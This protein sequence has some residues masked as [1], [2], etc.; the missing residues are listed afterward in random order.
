MDRQPAA[1][2]VRNSH[3]HSRSRSRSRSPRSKMFET[4]EYI[5]KEERI[6]AAEKV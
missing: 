4:A 1:P 3:A 6:L 2:D 5:K